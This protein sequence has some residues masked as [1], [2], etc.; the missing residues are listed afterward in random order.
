MTTR[1]QTQ[2]KLDRLS[3]GMMKH[4]PEQHYTVADRL[5]E[6]AA[7][8]PDSPFL[9]WNGRALSYGEVNAQA[10]RFAHHA[11]ASGLRP[12]DVAALL[13]ENR[14]EYLFVWFG[15]A[16]IGCVSALINTQASGEALRHALATTGSQRLFVGSECG[17]R[18]TRTPGVGDTLPLLAIA[19]ENQGPTPPGC[20]HIDADIAAQPATNPD[21]ALRSEVTG[22]STLCLVFTSGTTGLPKAARITHARWLGVGEG[23][24]ALLEA[25][26]DDVFYCALPLYHV[27]ALMSLMSN[28]LASGGRVVL[29]R[30]F[31]ASRFWADVREHGVTVAQYSGEMCR[32]LYNQPPHPDDRDH[33]LRAM[34]GSGLSPAIWLP[35]QERF[36]VT[37]MIEGYGGTEINVGLMNLDNRV[38]SCGR[39]PFPERSNARL[40][41]YDRDRDCYL[42]N[43]DGTL[44]DCADDE[45][46]EM[47]GMI[48]ELPGVTGGRFDGY[49]DPEATEKKILRN[50]FRPGD[51]WLR[52]GDLFRRDA[53][54]YY[55]FVDRVGDTFRWK[56]ENVSTTEVANVLGDA[57]GVETVT[58]YGVSIPG[59]EGRAGMATIVMQPGHAFDPAALYRLAREQ[60]PSYAVPV[61]VRVSDDTDITP[62]FKLRKVD[63]QKLG[64]RATPGDT[65]WVADPAA[66]RYVEA[67]ALNLARLGIPPSHAA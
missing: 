23:W 67:S 6:R 65:L 61:F 49:T 27:A 17:E 11:L 54:G 39:I 7:A 8:S 43:A 30:R 22:S 51:A 21:P 45:V 46:G 25:G 13:M 58:V 63:L 50:A 35:F 44:M 42:R 16:K 59:N 18:I 47:L 26:K 52:T 19:D 55:Y 24:A 37:Q 36:G 53:D 38:G 5:E 66:D 40:V 34:T 12:G 41:R 56:S 32:Y 4:T 15:L 33:R 28:A 9:L 1:E 64:Y 60:L 20:R 2:A 14:P 10:N 31:S 48:L 62:T 57:P 29:R 3:A